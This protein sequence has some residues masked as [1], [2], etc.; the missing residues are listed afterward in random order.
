LKDL[1]IRVGVSRTT[2]RHLEQGDLTVSLA[3]LIRTL[4][5]LGLADDLELIAQTDEIGHRLTDV[6]NPGPRRAARSSL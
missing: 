6:G 4:T 5:V 3:V 1:A 2:Q